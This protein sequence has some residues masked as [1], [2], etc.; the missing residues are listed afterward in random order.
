MSGQ[1]NGDAPGMIPAFPPYQKESDIRYPPP[2]KAF[3]FIDERSDSVDDGYFAITLS[4]PSW[5]NIP[6][7]WHSTGVVLSF[8]DA[9]AE[10]WRWKETT[11]V[12]DFFPYGPL[13]KP[14]DRDF[15]RVHAAYAWKD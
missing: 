11:T 12:K 14:T 1:M 8:A 6:A 10:H 2:S 15:D 13:T 5:Q 4:P 7:S 9:H 3:V